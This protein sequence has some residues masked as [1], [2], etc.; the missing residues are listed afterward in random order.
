MV[1]IGLVIFLLKLTTYRV[2]SRVTQQVESG[3]RA[4]DEIVNQKR[5]PEI[6][7]RPFRQRIDEIRHSGRSDDIEHVSR[8]AYKHCLRQLDSL[9]RFF[10]D[11]D[12]FDSPETRA[13]VL[14]SLREQREKWAAEDWK[15]LTESELNS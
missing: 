7:L 2:V 11:G 12:F 10:Q 8:R 15:A 9:I 6:W 3:F 1:C 5:V 13:M 4:A 14:E